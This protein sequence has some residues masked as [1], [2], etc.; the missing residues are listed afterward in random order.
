MAVQMQIDH[1]PAGIGQRVV[2]DRGPLVHQTNQHV[3]DQIEGAVMLTGQLICEPSKGASMG[4]H[5]RLEGL[6]GRGR[7]VPHTLL[8]TETTPTVATTRSHPP[9]R[10]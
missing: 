10:A 3:L 4:V 1:H 2:R 7:H 6:L 9:P 5:E 8:D